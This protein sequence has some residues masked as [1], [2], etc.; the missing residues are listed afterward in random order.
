MSENDTEQGASASGE[1]N[2]SDEAP[3]GTTMTASTANAA[4]PPQPPAHR[5]GPSWGQPLQRLE[6]AWARLETR[7]AVGVLLA[8]IASL[9]AW[10]FLKGMSTPPSSGK[11]GV[12]F[13]AVVTSLV[14]GF[15]TWRLLRGKSERL[16]NTATTVAAAAG[17]FLGR[18]WVG[19]GVTYSSE[20][21]NWYQDASTL[22]LIG[23]LRGVGTRLT[24]WLAMLGA[25]LATS[26][27][28]HINI[29]VVM[30]FLPPK[31]RIPAAAA[32]WLA[33]AAVCFASTWGFVDH[34]VIASFQAPKESTTGQK[35]RVLTHELREQFFV[36]RK[37][38]SLDFK[39][40]PR[41]FTGTKYTEALRGAEWNA[42][43]REGGYEAWFPKEQVESLL[44]KDEARA[45]SPLV[46]VP[47][48]N[49]RGLLV[50]TLN[51]LFPFGFLMM[52]LKFLLR[53]LLVFSGHVMVDPDA[54][55]RED[56]DDE[57]EGEPAAVEG[58]S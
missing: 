52:G 25:S 44:V 43:V 11:A 34:I 39:V 3:D 8:E 19:V 18:L 20:I 6:K 50:E 12:V 47:G 13:R 48:K 33:A 51:L 9:C 58:G 49:Q 37:Q 31:V 54:A 7:L 28:K 42:H 4:P 29:D 30:R 40:G 2:T 10:V 27:G 46:I 35:I 26:S 24:A 23:G 36:L 22:T 14:M 56:H 16:R 53:V 41:V 57:P 32:A 1:K 38:I 21:L 55:H 5:P 45:V 15:L 17:L